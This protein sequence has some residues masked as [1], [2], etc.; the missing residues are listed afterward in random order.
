MSIL[1]DLFEQIIQSEEK[2]RTRFLNLRKVSDEI[3]NY[4]VKCED[5]LDEMKSLQG[6][7]VLKN[8]RL[9]EEELNLKWFKIREEVLV[10]KRAELL[11]GRENLIKEKKKTEETISYHKHCPRLSVS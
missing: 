5:L 2:I 11:T 7:L 9:S 10:Q 3:Q 6:L 4:Q 8:Q 1:N